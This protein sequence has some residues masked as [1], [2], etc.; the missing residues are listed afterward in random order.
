LADS[1]YQAI[2][3]NS[4]LQP[5]QEQLLFRQ[6]ELYFFLGEYNAARVAYGKLMQSFP[7]SVYV[8]DCLRRIMLIS[9]Y[10]DME[11]ITLRVYSKALYDGFRFQY[12]SA[13]VAY[14]QLQKHG[15]ETLTELA[16]F[17]GGET[18]ELLDRPAEALVQYDS[19]IT[20]FPD[21]FYAPLAAEKKGDI[22]IQF[23][24]Q[25]E[26]A[27][28]VYEDILLN[29]PKSLNVDEVRRKLRQVQG[30][31]NGEIEPPKS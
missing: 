8:N 10:P 19:L 21:G 7:K 4:L 1:L 9:E 12:D 26:L 23:L 3:L 17:N 18:L 20:L 27:K 14:D 29:H 15:G 13:L 2:P 25:F 22:Y 31:I 24:A 6:G 16:W 30:I 28:Q 5:Y 11:E